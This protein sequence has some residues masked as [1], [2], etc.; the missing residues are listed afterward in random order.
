ML[1]IASWVW[2]YLGHWGLRVE[3]EAW[4]GGDREG[5]DVDAWV[6]FAHSVG[7]T[8][9]SGERENRLN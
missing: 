8:F 1:W 2:R 9:V 6:G 5:C 3:K 4:L 7:C